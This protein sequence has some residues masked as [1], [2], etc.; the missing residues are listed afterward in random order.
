LESKI[1]SV[2]LIH[3]QIPNLKGLTVREALFIL[4]NMGLEVEIKGSGKVKKQSLN[5]GT[6]VKEN[7]KITIELS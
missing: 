6:R 7:Q 1:A 2:E 4:E 3:N 5:A